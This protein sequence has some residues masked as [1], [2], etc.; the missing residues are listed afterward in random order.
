MLTWKEYRGEY[1]DACLILEGRGRF[2][3]TCANA[4]CGTSSTVTPTFRCLDCFGYGLYC[5]QCIVT[6]HQVNPL[7]QIEVKTPFNFRNLFTYECPLLGK[8]KPFFPKDHSSRSWS[9]CTT[10]TCARSGLPL[11]PVRS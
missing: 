5:R 8:E 6:A 10:W 7:H 11:P 4:N 3:K 2:F 1:L 9:S